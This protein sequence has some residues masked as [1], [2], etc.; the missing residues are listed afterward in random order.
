MCVFVFVFPCVSVC[1]HLQISGVY[2]TYLSNLLFRDA[3]KK[4]RLPSLIL[5]SLCFYDPSLGSFWFLADG[6]LIRR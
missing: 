4:K 1:R 5:F 3:A 2:I 6:C